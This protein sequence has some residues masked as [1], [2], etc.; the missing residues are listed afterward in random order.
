MVNYGAR[1][2]RMEDRDRAYTGPVI[3]VSRIVEKS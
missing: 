3:P 1:Q 2:R